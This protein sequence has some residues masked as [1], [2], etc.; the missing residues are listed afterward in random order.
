MKYSYKSHE[1]ALEYLVKN[2]PHDME[3]FK[4][5]N[6]LEVDD[7]HKAKVDLREIL[8][9]DVWTKEEKKYLINLYDYTNDHRFKYKTYD[10]DYTAGLDG[11]TLI[12][13]CV[14]NH[15]ISG[16]EALIELGSPISVATVTR[17][18]KFIEDPKERMDFSK[19]LLKY[20]K[21]KENF[22]AYKGTG[23]QCHLTEIPTLCDRY[24][25]KSGW[26][27]DNEF[28]MTFSS[29]EAVCATNDVELIK[30]YLETVKDVNNILEYAI[31]TENVEVMKLLKERG[32]D[33]N[34]Q[35]LTH[36]Y[37]NGRRTFKTPLKQAINNNDL[38][39]IKYLHENGADL[40]YVN[41]SERIKGFVASL[42][43]AEEKKEGT[44]VY[45][46]ESDN[47][48]YMVWQYSP[49]EY[50]INLGPASIL[51]NKYDPCTNNGREISELLSKRMNIVKY[52]YEN[53][54]KFTDGSIN[55][56]DLICF[57]IKADDFSSTEY[58]FKEAEKNNA[59]LDFEKIIKFIH[60]PGLFEIDYHTTVA[61]DWMLKEANEWFEMCEKYSK[62]LDNDNY[63]R[64]IK[65]MLEKLLKEFSYNNYI[66][67]KYRDIII[68][69]SKK[70]PK[71]ELKDIPI[72][73]TCATE[74]L[75]E[76]MSLGYDINTINE[77]GD[78]G[79]IYYIKNGRN[80]KD[81]NVLINLGIDT[82][83]VNPY[84]NETALSAAIDEIPRVDFGA[85]ID[86]F[87]KSIMKLGFPVEEYNRAQKEV[88]LRILD[89]TADQ[90]INN[91]VVKDKI[92]NRISSAW[93][94]VIY[95]DLMKKFSDKG[96]KVDDDYF[97]KILKDL[98]GSYTDEYV[99]EWE[100]LYNLYSF[101]DN[102]DVSLNQRFPQLYR[103]KEL[104]LDKKQRDNLK[105]LIVEHIKRNYITN[106]SQIDDPK[107]KIL[108]YNEINRKDELE[109]K[110]EEPK[111]ILI[112]EIT[113]YIGKL[114]YRD[115]MDIIKSFD[116]LDATTLTKYRILE[117][118]L[119]KDVKLAEELIKFGVTIV[120]KND[121]GHDVTEKFYDEEDIQKF[122]TLGGEYNDF[123]EA[124]DILLTIGCKKK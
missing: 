13:E 68:D 43:T 88:V 118:A 49:L 62:K 73:F 18:M 4:S 53:G 103:A 74:L 106:E 71:E 40:N 64:N 63:E 99:D 66:Y 47:R 3:K 75:K 17:I 57:A 38:E 84:T 76:I 91:P 52:L 9:S 121:K 120:L 2:D 22:K 83:Y 78:N 33:F 61:Y 105:S 27:D 25:I 87:D 36:K 72:V 29:M 54:A 23:N 86:K 80:L 94:F 10:N 59:K 108:V 122:I 107:D 30:L 41:S 82:S 85:Y 70:V 98:E 89:L 48:D 112:R 67:E 32:A 92:C 110:I 104:N 50:A 37:D 96:L 56:T 111:R 21:D 46:E 28:Y 117:T 20:Y 7:T 101:F 8:F 93:E 1:K 81:I 14:K 16:M 60:K 11:Y 90:E 97:R 58:F 123:E 19:S 26:F 115:V 114:D 15:S 116:I 42:G 12:D 31:D 113:N 102:T 79:L 124:D 77:D 6:E 45:K 39:M 69:F 109:F 65:L 95:S 5:L 24:D 100:Y 119:E 44:H 51:G 35:D 34:Y 55:Y